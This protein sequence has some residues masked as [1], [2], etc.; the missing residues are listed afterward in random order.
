MAKYYAKNVFGKY[1]SWSTSMHEKNP[2]DFILKWKKSKAENDMIK[3]I[4][5]TTDMRKYARR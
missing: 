1:D 4:T 2:H 5:T 3:I